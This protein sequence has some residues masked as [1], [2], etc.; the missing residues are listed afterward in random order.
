MQRIVRALKFCTSNKCFGPNCGRSFKD[1]A[2]RKAHYVR[3]HG[4][5][6]S[7]DKPPPTRRKSAL[8][9]GQFKP[10][11]KFSKVNR[12]QSEDGGEEDDDSCIDSEVSSDS[13]MSVDRPPKSLVWKDRPRIRPMTLRL[14]P[15]SATPQPQSRRSK[16]HP[17]RHPSHL[18]RRQSQHK[19]FN[20]LYHRGKER[21]YHGHMD[22]DCRVLGHIP[23]R[24]GTTQTL[25]NRTSMTI[26]R[27]Q[28]PHQIPVGHSQSPNTKIATHR[29]SRPV[30]LSSQET[31]MMASPPGKTESNQA[32]AR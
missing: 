7:N 14:N 16:R 3:E 28:R 31:S 25:R 5:Y 22:Q 17:S 13:S 10:G 4:F 18:L 32:R 8:K 23:A 9:K 2:E 6:K 21:S 15:T 24:N 26:S 30:T 19:L 1:A 20:L 29:P 12:V 27:D 11:V